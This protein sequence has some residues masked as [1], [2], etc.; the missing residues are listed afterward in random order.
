MQLA[1]T[2][3]NIA[4]PAF[5]VTPNRLCDGD[6]YGTWRCAPDY[7]ESLRQLADMTSDALA[8]AAFL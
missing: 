6:H 2:G 5:D 7:R 1:P 4:N 3:I 8:I